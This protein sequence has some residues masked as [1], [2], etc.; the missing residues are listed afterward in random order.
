MTKL[1]QLNDIPFLTDGGMETVLIFR[2][3][4][5]LPFFAS[6][7]LLSN[8]NGE[9]IIRNYYLDYI[10]LARKY[11]YGFILESPT[12][13]ASLGWGKMLGYN[14][15]ELNSIN[16][17]AIDLLQTIKN[18]NPDIPM[19]VSGCIGPHGDGY[20]VRKKMSV[21]EAENYHSHQI[22][23]FKC[24]GAD[25]ATAMTMTYAEEAIGITIAAQNVDLPIVISFTV[26]TDGKLPSGQSLKAAIKQVDKATKGGP[27]Y[28]MI[29]CAHP[30]HFTDILEAGSDWMLRI[31]GLRCNASKCSHAELDEAERLDEGNPEELGRAIASLNNNHP[32][33]TVLG[34]CC[35]TNHRHLEEICKALL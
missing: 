12:W 23:S 22:K 35:G 21:D 17:K 26:E 34:G 11:G 18:N 31:R 3:G 29:N 19:I 28:Y 16:I 27:A 4:I 1:S 33:L 13:R 15:D 32:Q 5:D 2:H 10:R 14:A 8:K 6:F 9:E 24:N 25:I 7:K 20:V 30:E